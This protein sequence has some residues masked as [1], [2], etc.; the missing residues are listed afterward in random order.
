MCY[1]QNYYASIRNHFIKT[2]ILKYQSLLKTETNPKNIC[3]Y[4]TREI[5]LLMINPRKNNPLT[6]EIEI[7]MISTVNIDRIE[8][9]IRNKDF[10][11]TFD[12]NC[13]IVWACKN[14]LLNIVEL[15]LRDPRV[16][17]SAND[18]EAIL[19]ACVNH[20][21]KLMRLLLGDPRV[22]PSA[23]KNR[24][25]RSMS[26]CCT[27]EFIEILLKYPQVNPAQSDNVAIKFACAGR[28]V[29]VV[30]A[31]LKDPRVNPCDNNANNN[32]FE[33]AI[34]HQY[35]EIIKILLEDPRVNPSEND[36]YAM[37]HALNLFNIEIIELL[38]PRT[39]PAVIKN[40]ELM[41]KMNKILYLVPETTAVGL[42]ADFIR[43]KNLI[44]I[45]IG[46]D[47]I[48]YSKYV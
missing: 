16:D 25:I 10:D 30:K 29:E 46:D 13:M 7:L 37:N 9:I 31:L 43:N 35:L 44:K 3:D 20:N 42:I 4:L 11:P 47:K 5:K 39:D 32:A 17:P 19:E 2:D 6:N 36:N 23:Y 38:I 8:S 15:L 27:P 24:A 14:E 26:Y 1:L 33:Y 21:E 41:K 28:N 34:E 12:N 18:N 40:H 22:D 48:K 45:D